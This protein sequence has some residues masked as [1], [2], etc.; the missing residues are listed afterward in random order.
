MS[1]KKR[2]NREL[3]NSQNLTQRLNTLFP[4]TN[5]QYRMAQ[6]LMT[7]P[8]DHPELQQHAAEASREVSM[9]RAALHQLL[10]V[11]A[12]G[13]DLSIP[14]GRERAVEQ[15]IA[16]YRLVNVV[17]VSHVSVDLA[18]P[19]EAA[20]WWDALIEAEAQTNLDGPSDPEMALVGLGGEEGPPRTPLIL[21]PDA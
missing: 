5:A 4:A 11:T 7:T 19:E 6:S 16:L 17:A 3:A 1:F 13:K 9:M 21:T 14:N 15:A 8:Q 12:V 20:A 10:R 2:P 18:S